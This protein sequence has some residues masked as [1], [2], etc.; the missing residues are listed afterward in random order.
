MATLGILY[1]LLNNQNWDI[2]KFKYLINGFIYCC[3]G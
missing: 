3:F 2:I 1:F